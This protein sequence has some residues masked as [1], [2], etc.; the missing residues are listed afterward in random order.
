MSGCAAAQTARA[1]AQLRPNST[2]DT[3]LQSNC[4]GGRRSNRALHQYRDLDR[5]T[6]DVGLYRVFPQEEI[7]VRANIGLWY[8]A[9]DEQVVMFNSGLLTTVAYQLGPGQPVYYALEVHTHAT[10]RECN[11][12]VETH[13]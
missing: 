10:L 4:L 6:L 11:P 9:S 13:I 8:P 3:S 5:R 2:S 7:G 1:R 12:F